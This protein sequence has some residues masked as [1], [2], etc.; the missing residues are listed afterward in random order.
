[1]GG[2]RQGRFNL[3]KGMRLLVIVGGNGSVP[4]GGYNGGGNGGGS[5]G[6]GGG[7][8]SEVRRIINGVPSKN[9]PRL[10]VGGGGG[11]GG[12]TATKGGAGDWGNTIEG[13]RPLAL[14]GKGGPSNPT[15]GGKGGKVFSPLQESP[16]PSLGG[17]AGV[18][19]APRT[20]RSRAGTARLLLDLKP[21]TVALP[22]ISAV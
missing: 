14:A 13:R 11:G 15:A 5:S 12:S 16:L 4:T 18:W 9:L 22:P 21:A 10:V 7:G 6:G 19:D 3:K 2:W 1:M 20:P 17:A 8:A